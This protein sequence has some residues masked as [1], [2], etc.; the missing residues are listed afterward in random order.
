MNAYY[1]IAMTCVGKSNCY[2][3]LRFCGLAGV[4]A[5]SLQA[6]KAAR[7]AYFAGTLR[8]QAAR[9][10]TVKDRQQH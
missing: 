8:S 6:P 7:G 2:K 10:T 1:L 4:A 5:A 9:A 3:W